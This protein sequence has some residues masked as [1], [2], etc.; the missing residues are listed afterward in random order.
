[1]PK[2][3]IIRI[4]IFE[5]RVFSPRDAFGPGPVYWGAYTA[6]QLLLSKPSWGGSRNLIRPKLAYGDGL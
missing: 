1:M 3:E 5:I 2:S 6:S 4:S